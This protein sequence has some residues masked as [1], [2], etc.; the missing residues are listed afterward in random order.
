MPKLK[1]EIG[2]K[3]GREQRRLSSDERARLGGSQAAEVSEV[4][5]DRVNLAAVEAACGIHRRPFLLFLERKDE[6]TWRVVRAHPLPDTLGRGAYPYSGSA[7][8]FCRVARLGSFGGE[9]YDCESVRGLSLL[10]GRQRLSL[11]VRCPQL[12]GYPAT[13]EA[14]GCPLRTMQYLVVLRW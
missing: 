7:G 13:R 1:R 2:G 8:A 14:Q 11:W 6:A 4:G 3:D 9:D 5:S 12:K 10:L